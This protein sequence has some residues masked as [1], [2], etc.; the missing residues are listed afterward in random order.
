MP[1]IAESRNGQAPAD[2]AH[3]VADLLGREEGTGGPEGLT[4]GRLHAAWARTPAGDANGNETPAD[5]RPA[6]A[7][8]CFED[9]ESVVGRFMA[10]VSRALARRQVAVHAFVRRGFAAEGT[11]L[12][13]HELGACGEGDLL[14]QVQEFTHRACNAFLGLFPAGSPP[15]TLLGHEWSAVPSLSLLRG[16]AP[17]DALLSLHSLERQRGGLDSDLSRQIDALEAAGLR[18]ARAV[19]VQDPATAEVAKYW[20]PECAP[21]IGCARQPFPAE[22]FHSRLDPGAVKARFQVGPVDPT[23][24]YLGDL[25]ERYGPDLLVKAMPAVLKDVKQA[26]LVVVGD[27]ALYW[28]LRVYARYLLLEH[29]VRLPGHLEGQALYELIAAA[30]VVA[31]PSRASTPWWPIQAAWAAGRPVV[32]THVAAPGL[33]EHEQDA[34]LVHPA[35]NSCVWGIERVLFDAG[36]RQTLAGKGAAKLEERFGWGSVA[37]QVEE[38][39][40][41]PAA[42]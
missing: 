41:V 3:R 34:V 9:P 15:V 24:L 30:D 10:H 11:G 8:F 23:I 13:L 4:A 40:G 31:V 29:A 6:L 36:L 19:L 5:D 35:E 25:D 12:H 18:Q 17:Y 38:L 7:V 2:P 32:A 42:R 26:R 21:R 16:L 1:E 20:V 22:K 14:A 27:G 39:L 37:A 33:L 28:P